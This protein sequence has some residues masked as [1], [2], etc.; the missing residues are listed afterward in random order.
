MPSINLQNNPTPSFNQI[1]D[2]FQNAKTKLGGEANIR[3]SG[4]TLHT[5]SGKFS[6]V[7]T[8]AAQR[9]QMKK[10]DAKTFIKNSFVNHLVSN[11][12]NR[13][14]ALR[15]TAKITSNLKGITGGHAQ[16]DERVW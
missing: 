8:E 12:I 3:M 2:T 14:D 10:D 1:L 7:G 13:A 11:G 15:M 5:K 6:G 4:N 16:N 9:R